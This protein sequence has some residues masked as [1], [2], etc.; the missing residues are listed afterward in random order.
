MN[1]LFN[2]KRKKSPEHSQPDSFTTDVAAGPVSYQA[3]SNI[4]PVGG[5]SRS[6]QDPSVDRPDLTTALDERSGGGSQIDFQD[7]MDEDQELPVLEAWASGAAIDG[8]ARR[9]N[10]TSECSWSPRLTPMSIVFVR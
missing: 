5:Q 3:Q 2:S 7:R 1:R 10:P 9:H 4:G 8:A 6:Y